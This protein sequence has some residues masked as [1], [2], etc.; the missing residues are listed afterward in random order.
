MTATDVKGENVIAL[1][2]A[3]FYFVC[4]FIG[5]KTKLN[6]LLKQICD[7]AQRFF[8]IPSYKWY[9]VS[10]GIYKILSKIRSEAFAKVSK[11][12]PY[13]QLKLFSEEYY[14]YESYQ[15]GA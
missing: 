4:V 6:I 7:K 5:L 14:S 13:T 12:H 10:D 2:L 9:A 15:F 11:S 1:V 8:Q 3:V